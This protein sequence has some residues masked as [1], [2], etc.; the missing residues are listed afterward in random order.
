MLA[1]LWTEAGCQSRRVDP[2]VLRV[3]YLSN[4][5][6]LVALSAAGRHSYERALA[7]ARVEW[8]AFSAGPEEMEALFA[9]AIDVGYVGPGPAQIA[10]LRSRGEALVVLA[11]AASGGAALLVRGEASGKKA[12]ITRIEDLHGAALATPQLGNTQDVALRTFL[13]D[14]GL[15]TLERGGDVRVM[16][17]ANS[18]VPGLFLRGDLDGAWVPEPWVSILRQGYGARVLVDERTLW[19]E[20]RFPTTVVVAARPAIE[21]KRDLVVRFVAAHAA[22]VAWVRAHPEETQKIVGERI[23]QITGK[24]LPEAVL[25]SALAA[26]EPTLDPLRAALMTQAAHAR[27][28]GYLPAGSLDGLIDGSLLDAAMKAGQSV[29]APRAASAADGAPSP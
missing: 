2:T 3:G 11:G 22:E 29:P 15:K 26:I 10:Y 6:H 17:L 21:H 7:P 4:V 14:H 8:R 25:V 24:A 18:S 5:T 27:R 20:G 13:F 28:L 23:R 19:P 12:A 1:A 9:G 16:P